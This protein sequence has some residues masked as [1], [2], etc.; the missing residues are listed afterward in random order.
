MHIE[1][2]SFIKDAFLL[3]CIVNN[4]GGRKIQIM[5]G[6]EGRLVFKQKLK[7]P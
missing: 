7:S 2:Y 3:L 5:L 1:E 4:V 6:I